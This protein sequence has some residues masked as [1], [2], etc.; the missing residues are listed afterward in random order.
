MKSPR[1]S[2]VERGSAPNASEDA[3]QALV[4]LTLG[5]MAREVDS[6]LRWAH[7]IPNG[8]DRDKVSAGV[9]I[10]T[11]TRSGVFDVCLPF[12]S[13]KWPFAAI[14]I[15]RPQ[16][17]NHKN[18]GLGD[19]QVLYAKHLQLVGAWWAVTYGAQETIDAIKLYLEGKPFYA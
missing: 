13:G 12:P 14:E 17:R 6:R 2:I 11:G 15:K 19:N 10:A 18:G 1:D 7:A 9:M 16:V 8:G 5:D 3:I 4:F